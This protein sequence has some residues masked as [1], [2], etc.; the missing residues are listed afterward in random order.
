MYAVVLVGAALV[1]GLVI[2]GI[3]FVAVTRAGKIGGDDP[4]ESD[5]GEE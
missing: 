5:G 2:M 3:A 4:R 1:V